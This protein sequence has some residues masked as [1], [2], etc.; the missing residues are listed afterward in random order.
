[1]PGDAHSC[2]KHPVVEKYDKFML[3][4]LF[5]KAP[6]S[7]GIVFDET[8]ISKGWA[9]WPISFDPCWLKSCVLYEEKE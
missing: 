3:S 7:F 6:N 1:M 4:L 5:L 9:L 8:G 2:C